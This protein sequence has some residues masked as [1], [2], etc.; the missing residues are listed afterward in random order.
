MEL[1]ENVTEQ[2]FVDI[3]FRIARKISHRYVFTSYETADIEQEAFLIAVEG[4]NRYDSSKPLENFL[5]VHIN[6]RLKNLKRKVY[7]RVE[8]GEAQKIQDVKK[9]ILDAVDIG[10]TQSA[11]T[12]CVFS[13]VNLKEILRIIDEQLPASMRGDYLRLRNKGKITKARKQKIIKTIDNIIGDYFT[14]ED[15]DEKG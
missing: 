6:N 4:M 11:S 13:N 12:E 14:M 2:Q 9:H 5:Y 10:S 1:P 3:V 15:F 8:T 7:Y